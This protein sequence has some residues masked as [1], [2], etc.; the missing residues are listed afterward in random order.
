MTWTID[1]ELYAHVEIA[2][3]GLARH[4]TTGGVLLPRYERYVQAAVD[5]YAAFAT[6]VGVSTDP[7]ISKRAA[8]KVIFPTKPPLLHVNLLRRVP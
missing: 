6:A 4:D 2:N 5:R 8:L 7:V 3:H 1:R